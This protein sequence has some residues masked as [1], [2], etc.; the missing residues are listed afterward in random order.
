M[1]WSARDPMDS[2]QRVGF[3]ERAA[4]IQNSPQANHNAGITKRVDEANIIAEF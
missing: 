2:R 3:V 1:T 4:T